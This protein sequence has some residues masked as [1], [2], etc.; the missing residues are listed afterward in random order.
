MTPKQKLIFPSGWQLTVSII[1][2][3]RLSQALRFVIIVVNNY[4]AQM[5]YVVCIGNT[6]ACAWAL[7]ALGSLH[8]I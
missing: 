2:K 7:Y 6:S 1:T 5:W 4:Y 3:T 8:F